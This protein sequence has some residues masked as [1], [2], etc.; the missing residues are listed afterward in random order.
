MMYVTPLGVIPRTGYILY[1]LFIQQQVLSSYSDLWFRFNFGR[2][3]LDLKNIYASLLLIPLMCF[4][5]E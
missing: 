1:L 2:G 5:I 3:Y 4:A